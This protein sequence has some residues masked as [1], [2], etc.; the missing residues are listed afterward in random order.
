M[1]QP[2]PPQQPPNDPFRK[3]QP[4]DAPPP[5]GAFGPPP[6]PLPA[7]PPAPP[8]YGQQPYAQ[9]PFGAQQQP[10]YGQAPGPQYPYGYPQGYPQPPA[11]QPFPQAAGRGKLDSP[12]VWIITA[13]VV[14]IALVI[15]GGILYTAS[16][17][18]GGDRNTTADGRKG[19]GADGGQDKGGS[20]LGEPGQEKVP[21]N[22][23]AKA[24]FQLAAPKVAKKNVDS[25][26]G[27]WL[28]DRT[29]A[30]AGVGKIV[31]Y[32]PATGKKTW[33]L[34]LPGQTCGGT[35]D[36]TKD[37]LA[38]VVSE[39]AARPA[40]GSHRTCS[41]ITLFDVNTGKKVW[42]KSVGSGTKAIPFE[43]LSF[44][45]DTLAV[46]GG[47]R[48]GA[49]L[50]VRTG[51]V[52]WQPM[53][54]SCEDVGYAGGA[55]LVTVRTCGDY[56][57]ERYE[58]QLLDPKTGRPKWTYQLAADVE[59][60]KVLSTDPVVIGVGRGDNAAGTVSGILS[61]DQSGRLV[62][63]IPVDDEKY[64]FDCEVGRVD[65]CQKIVVGNGRVYL[66][67][68]QHDGGGDIGT[69]N[70]IVSYDLRSGKPTGDRADGGGFGIFPVRMDGGNVLAY[71][72]D[73]YG[74]G[75]RIVSI[76]PRSMKQTTLL[77]TPTTESVMRALSSM[78]VGR[79]GSEV[80]YSNGRLFLGKSLISAPYAKDVKDY[81]AIAFVAGG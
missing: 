50:D 25:V 21:A 38:A 10:Q 66:A 70:E 7:A 34:P 33:T 65:G 60:A 79:T 47:L 8:A 72:D 4:Q 71:K 63:E 59:S 23:S 69:T 46:G 13:A 30:K 39:D 27:S 58:A 76:D 43:E 80:R 77:R 44:S 40:D 55:Q 74:K 17:D 5:A 53:T 81:T 37:A 19:V 11:A 14:V 28:T 1:T 52:L 51:K 68:R 78:V 64:D 20:G 32:D 3:E 35:Q 48:G 6:P 15:G 36:V 26:R 2:P 57:H 22:T 18:G 62:T 41:R 73:P 12:V 54:G 16:D 56:G 49:A 45:G 31:G 24:A 61:M 75:A 67:T 42:T 9:P 29:Y